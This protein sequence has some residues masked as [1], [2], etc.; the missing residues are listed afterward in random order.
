[1]RAANTRRVAQKGDSALSRCPSTVERLVISSSGRVEM[2]L[3]GGCLQNAPQLLV[4]P[5]AEVINKYN[6]YRRAL[7]RVRVSKDASRALAR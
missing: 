7:Q 4:N 6:A 5:L 2:S 3:N 1:M